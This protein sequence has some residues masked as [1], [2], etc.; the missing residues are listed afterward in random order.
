ME[1]WRE[2]RSPGSTEAMRQMMQQMQR[3]SAKAAG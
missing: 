1:E 3:P 2:K